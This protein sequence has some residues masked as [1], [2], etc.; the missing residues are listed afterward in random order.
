MGVE[1]MKRHYNNRAKKTHLKLLDALRHEN[2]ITVFPD[3]E[4]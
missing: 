4:S 3:D 1:T 2:D